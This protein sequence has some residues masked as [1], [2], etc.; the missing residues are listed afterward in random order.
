M[1][2]LGLG[3]VNVDANLCPERPSVLG[4][5]LQRFGQIV[6]S[7]LFAWTYPANPFRK[8]HTIAFT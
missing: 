6:T 2:I 4:V 5:I 1:G 3:F 8:W 7:S